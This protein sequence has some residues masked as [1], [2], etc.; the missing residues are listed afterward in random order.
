M[1][2][3]IEDDFAD[4]FGEGADAGLSSIEDMLSQ[5]FFEDVFNDINDTE[6]FEDYQDQF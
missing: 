1:V 2:E 5:S 3:N 4:H 6:S